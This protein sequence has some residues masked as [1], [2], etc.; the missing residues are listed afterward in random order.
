MS[1][2]L[3]F[4]VCQWR[5]DQDGWSVTVLFGI[6]LIWF[7][8]NG[9]DS[10]Q[11]LVF[12][13][14]QWLDVSVIQLVYNA[15]EIHILWVNIQFGILIWAYCWCRSNM[16]IWWKV[17]YMFWCVFES[18]GSS[19]KHFETWSTRCWGFHPSMRV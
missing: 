14:I 3:F 19:V 15:S 17:T 6:A 9:G 10:T 12:F 2:V 5:L 11:W 13:I 1:Y 18:N 4:V 7:G 8:C 16:K